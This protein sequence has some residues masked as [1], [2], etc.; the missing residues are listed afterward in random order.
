[1][2]DLPTPRGFR[3][4]RGYQ[5]DKSVFFLRLGQGPGNALAGIL[6]CWRL[7]RWCCS[8]YDCLMYF[9]DLLLAH[10]FCNRF[11]LVSDEILAANNL[12]R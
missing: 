2:D 4:D 6:F 9:P 8:S 12:T 3:A 11:L 10:S 5:E 1:M 7:G